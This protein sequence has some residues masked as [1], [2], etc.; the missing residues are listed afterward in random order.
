LTA[1]SIIHKL[2]NMSIILRPYQETGLQDI[3][4]AW[5]AGHQNVLYVAATGS[6]KTVTFSEAVRR[7]DGPAIAIA[8][9]QEL[10]GQISLALAR[11]GIRHRIIAPDTVIRFCVSVHMRELKRSYYDANAR[12]GVAGVDT[13]I[14]RTVDRWLASVR[15][16]VMDECHHVLKKNKWGLAFDMF[17]QAVGL[18]VTATPERADGRGLGRHA[19]GVF[20]TMILAPTMRDMINHGFLTDYRIFAPPSDLDLSSVP[21]A[22]GGDYS[23]DPLRKAVHKSHIVGDVV[24]QYLKSAA[25]LLGVTFSVDVESAT[26]QAAAFRRAGV[27]AEVVSAKTPDPVRVSILRKFAAGDIKQLVNVDLF[28]EGFDL[29]AIEAVSMARPT[30][31]FSLY[32]QQ[33]GRALRP[34]P[35]K[36]WAIIN[37]H[38]QNVMRHG[39]P[40]APRIWTLDRREKRS[41]SST[42][43]PSGLSGSS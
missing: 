4:A 3:F 23:Q 41:R 16:V 10:V 21:L 29:P 42:V 15:L 1:L 35:G 26:E 28:G 27:P 8:H 7:F 14:R 12:V 32:S 17:P 22:S 37:D 40:D 38:V 20:D 18:G 9:R 6:G 34:L 31:S 24:T 13:L 39:V 2:T 43:S 5:N 11:N 25:G 19:D 30:Q 33:F 36:Q